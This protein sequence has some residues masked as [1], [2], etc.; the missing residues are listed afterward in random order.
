MASSLCSRCTFL[1]LNS[2][3]LQKKGSEK[4][5]LQLFHFFHRYGPSARDA[6]FYASKPA[7]YDTLLENAV[8]RINWETASRAVSHRDPPYMD[9]R[10]YLTLLIGPTPFNRRRYSVS[11]ASPAAME[12]LCRR[13]KVDSREQFRQYF[14][15]LQGIPD[16]WA[17]ARLLLETRC[18]RR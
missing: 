6:Y 10:S 9:A 11:V 12:Q 3:P 13:R 17:T 8:T 4:T 7:R 5:A 18:M 2:L 1:Y 15:L 14:T 16:S